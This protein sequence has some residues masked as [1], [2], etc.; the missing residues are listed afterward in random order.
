VTVVDAG[1]VSEYKLKITHLVTVG[2]S[3]TYCQGLEN[4]LNNGWPAIIAKTLNVPLVNLGSP[5]VGNDSIHRKTY[6]YFY[7]NLP[8]NSNP[9]FII[10]WSQYWR[11]EA[12]VVE[13]YRNPSFKDYAPIGLN[14]DRPENDHERAIL[15]DWNDLE[16]TRRTYLLK[17][18][19][20]NL[21]SSHNTP[22]LMTD[23]ALEMNQDIVANKLEMMF[24]NLYKAVHTDPNKIR[25]FYEISADYPKTECGHDGVD[26]NKAIAEYTLN[27][28]QNRY[29]EFTNEQSYLPLSTYIRTQKYMLKFPEWCSFELN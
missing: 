10:A 20:M 16:F 18:S 5:G 25:N 14:K 21:F 6:E 1:K 24:P 19:L 9:L 2:C 28:I 17:L 13:H 23:Y 8:T 12:W 26:G 27:E 3:F 7:E 4:K 11:K 15:S 29:N 22:Y